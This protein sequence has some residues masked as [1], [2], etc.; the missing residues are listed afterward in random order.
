MQDFKSIS[1]VFIEVYILSEVPA[2]AAKAIRSSAT[3]AKRKPYC[4]VNIFL[5]E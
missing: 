5:F 3:L 4:F 2:L 1:V